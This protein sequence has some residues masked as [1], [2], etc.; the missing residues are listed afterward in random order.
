MSEVIKN[1]Y[2]FIVLF[3]VENGN[4]NGDPDAA[5]MPRVDPETNQGIVTDVCLKK[6]IRKYVETVKENEAGYSIYIRDDEPLN[7][8]DG[9]AFEALGIDPKN[10]RAAAKNDPSF[11]I[12]LRD[13]MC[14]NYFDIRTFGAV[15]TGFV[16]AKLNCGQVCGPVQFS[17]ARSIDPIIQQ[18]IT[19]TRTA[20]ATEQD[21]ISKGSHTMGEKFIVPYALYRAHGYISA[22]LARKTTGFSEDDLELLWNAIINMF[23]YDR[24]AARGNMAV[25]KLIIF[26]HSNELGNAPAHKLFDLVSVKKKCEEK[27]AR[28]FSDYDVIIDEEHIPENVSII[29]KD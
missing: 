14:K 9:K 19:I 10:T 8:K 12:K 1:R 6:K 20:Q 23:E 25:R 27:P 18:D 11:E 4:P 17:F 7:N 24:S 22:N 2:E 15:L 21:F 29:Y 26:K 3:D 16:S 5:N 28:A 13:F